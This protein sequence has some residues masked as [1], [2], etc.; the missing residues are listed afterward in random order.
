LHGTIRSMRMPDD[1]HPQLV[2]FT[3]QFAQLC[4]VGG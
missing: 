3:H 4:G 2:V 1:Y